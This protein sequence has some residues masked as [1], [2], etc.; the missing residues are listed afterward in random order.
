MPCFEAQPVQL[1]HCSVSPLVLD[2][3]ALDSVIAHLD[4]GQRPSG[5]SSQAAH[6][7]AVPEMLPAL[8]T[9]RRDVYCWLRSTQPW[10]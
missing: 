7:W 4:G 2:P 9:L 1:W 8:I 10:Q 5:G 3:Q 6:D